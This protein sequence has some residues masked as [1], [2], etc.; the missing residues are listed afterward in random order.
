MKKTIF[1]SALLFLA[2]IPFAAAQWQPHNPVTAVQQQ[3][4]GVI[5]TQQTG[6]LKIVVCSDTVIHVLY[7][8]TANFAEQPDYVIVKKDWPGAKFTFQSDDKETV[9]TTAALKIV[10][11]RPD[12]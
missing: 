11:G 7:S 9:L 8:A 10:I 1:R 4:D 2:L 5:L 12:G 3:P 6:T